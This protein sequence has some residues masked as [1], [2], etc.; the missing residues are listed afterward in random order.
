MNPYRLILPLGLLTFALLLTTVLMGAR[1]IKVKIKVHKVFG[2][3]TFISA[4]TH[5]SL[6]IYLNY[7]Y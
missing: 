6:A 3:L 7:F 1:I 5:G 4:V 2:I